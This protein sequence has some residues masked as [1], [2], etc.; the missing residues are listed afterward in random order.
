MANFKACSVKP[1]LTDLGIIDDSVFVLPKYY[2]V[3][4]C[5]NKNNTTTWGKYYFYHF[6]DD[7]REAKQG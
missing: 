2:E 4:F 6:I 7:E 5:H 3:H 1:S